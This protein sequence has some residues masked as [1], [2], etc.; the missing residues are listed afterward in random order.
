MAATFKLK[1]FRAFSHVNTFNSIDT[2]I[3]Y[4]MV[5]RLIQKKVGAE[6]HRNKYALRAALFK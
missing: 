2:S 5:V 1:F 6:A 3:L 4:I